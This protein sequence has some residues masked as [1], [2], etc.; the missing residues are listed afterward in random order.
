MSVWCSTDDD[1]DDLS[2]ES[3]DTEDVPS[4][5]ALTDEVNAAASSAI[6]N[7]DRCR[8]SIV[9]ISDRVADPIGNFARDSPRYLCVRM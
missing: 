9:A 3:G 4:G 7:N 1:D 8:R 6:S 5:P 2:G